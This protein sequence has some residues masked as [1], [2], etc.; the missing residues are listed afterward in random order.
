MAGTVIVDRRLAERSGVGDSAVERARLGVESR[1][2]HDADA[3]V[4]SRHA[5]LVERR[6]ARPDVADL[7][8]VGRLAAV[9]R[10][11]GVRRQREPEEAEAPGEDEDAEDDDGQRSPECGRVHRTRLATDESNT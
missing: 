7:G 2:V 1:H 9:C 4:L 3:H 6:D 5:L 10:L 8:P 11:T